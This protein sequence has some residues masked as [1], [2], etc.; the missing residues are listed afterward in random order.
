MIDAKIK[1]LIVEDTLVVQKLLGGLIKNDDRFE[2]I[3]IAV[4]GKEAIDFVK[5]HKP[6][7][8]S[9]DILMPLMDGVEATRLIM[10]ENPIPIVIISG[11]YQSSE[12]E[13]AIKVMGV[14]AVAILPRPFGPGHSKYEQS[15]RQYLNMLKLMSE[16]KVVKRK[17]DISIISQKNPI[18]DIAV[19]FKHTGDQTFQ[20]LAIGA[21]AGGPEGIRTILSGLPPDFPLPVF[22]VQHIDI[23]FAEGFALWL[24]TFSKIP[25]SIA[26]NNE[27]ILP[28]HVY[29]P[30]SDQNI[31]VNQ[32]KTI[33]TSKDKTN[34]GIR[35]SVD[36]LFES[37]A[38]VYGKNS[39]AVIL[40]GMGKDG[41]IELKKLCDLG[42][43][44]IAQD[45]TSCLVYGMPG[46]AVK[47]GAACKVLSPENITKEICNLINL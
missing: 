40:S 13:M 21:S 28:G 12:I 38:N 37:I 45:E 31:R 29:L 27:N 26:I 15:A 34:I 11:L 43:Y 9:M 25:V 5:K 8:V 20:V 19:G 23:H 32:N 22:I 46:E 35:P 16:V 1:V 36:A 18:T 3:G 6:D 17:K 2:L 24:N 42:A 39:I 14:G 47:I 10:Q 30:P 44:T 33:M 4:N 7:V 41:A